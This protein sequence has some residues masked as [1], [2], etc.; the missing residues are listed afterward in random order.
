VGL[1]NIGLGDTLLQ[2]LESNSWNS[3]INS[4]TCLGIFCGVGDL[5]LVAGNLIPGLLSLADEATVDACLTE[6]N[7]V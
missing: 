2:T 7:L 1:E 6:L 3:D 4:S 5:A